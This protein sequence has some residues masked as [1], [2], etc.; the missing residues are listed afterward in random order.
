MNI[1]FKFV[2]CVLLLLFPVKGFAETIYDQ[3]YLGE[4]PDFFRERFSALALK[5]KAANNL[6]TIVQQSDLI[7]LAESEKISE[8]AESNDR[9]TI[10]DTNVK[11]LEIL[12]GESTDKF[13]NLKFEASAT[14][15]ENGPKHI[16]FLKRIKDNIKVL[17]ASFIFPR[18]QGYDNYMR[19]FGAY[20]CS[21]D[22]GID[23]INY[24]GNSTFPIDLD[25]RLAK[26]YLS[27][28]W[29]KM[30]SSVHMA[31]AISP[32]FG[33]PVLKMAVSVKDRKRF[34]ID[35]YG[36]A[37]Y[38]LAVQQNHDYWQTI[39]EN[40]PSFEGN[41][42][43]AESVAF[44]LA[45]TFGNEK[46]VPV[47]KDVVFKKPE[48]AVSAAFA[49]SKIKGKE[50]KSLIE[51]WLKD[52]ELSKREEIISNGWQQ[53]KTNFSTLFREALKKMEVTKEQ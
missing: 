6:A 48:L 2:I 38:S 13:L 45:A 34:D 32:V 50:A 43:V 27:E 52:T 28:S 46:I 22:I 41:G 5:Q 18:G 19:I 35:L 39:L 15:I 36:I 4:F 11:I 7:I 47:I 37:A 51:F 8:A 3:P 10:Y 20:D 24:L 44:D 31:S 49:L 25:E 16:F 23:V 12:K 17:K 33:V 26:E 53:R 30:Y 9:I 42:R 1:K 14:S 29:G 21:E 40:I